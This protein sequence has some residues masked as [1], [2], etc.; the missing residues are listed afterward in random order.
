[1]RTSNAATALILALLASP[2]GAQ[3]REWSRV[4][5][6]EPGGAITLTIDGAQPAEHVFVSAD[7]NGLTIL[8]PDGPGLPSSVARTLRRLAEQQ[9]AILETASK[10]GT[11][12][13]D[14]L[15]LTSG[16]VFVG[17]RKL[18]DLESVVRTIARPEVAEISVRRQ[19]RGFWGH[20][21][22]LGG[23]F[24]GAMAAGYGAG[25]VCSAAA[26]RQ[27]CD[28]GGF[29]V[30]MVVGGLAGGGYGFHAARREVEERA[31]ARSVDQNRAIST[32]AAPA[33][34]SAATASVWRQ[35]RAADG[36]SGRWLTNANA[37]SSAAPAD[38]KATGPE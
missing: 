36:G 32:T 11:V 27:R 4:R 28:S 26:G 25:A 6:L 20:L 10:G 2:V 7:A 21:G 24:V 17:D 22:A 19:G 15:R 33:P 3:E 23:G 35:M 31:Y 13:V 1:M 38:S 18:A 12:L 5:R 29:M 8:S 37:T 14:N 30:G 34:M 9:P 16:G